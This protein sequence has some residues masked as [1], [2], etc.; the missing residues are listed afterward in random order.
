[1]KS[2]R[3]RPTAACDPTEPLAWWHSLLTANPKAAIANDQV[4]E[5]LRLLANY[6][7]DVDNRLTCT[8]SPG[9][10]GAFTANITPKHRLTAV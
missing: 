1:M 4:L 8:I 5:D 2:V 3:S 6:Q 7:M 10:Q 9:S